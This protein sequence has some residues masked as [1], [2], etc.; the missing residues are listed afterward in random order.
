MCAGRHRATQAA[1]AAATLPGPTA[2]GPIWLYAARSAGCMEEGVGLGR[3]GIVR[4]IVNSFDLANG[5]SIFQFD[6]VRFID[7][8]AKVFGRW[9]QWIRDSCFVFNFCKS[10]IKASRFVS[11]L[12]LL[13]WFDF[14]F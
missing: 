5:L 4:S 1:A 11:E 10:K 8:S 6:A 14:K 13:L 12:I 9:V 3:P 7:F 2:G